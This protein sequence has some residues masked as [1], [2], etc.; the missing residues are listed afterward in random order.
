MCFDKPTP[1]LGHVALE[2]REWLGKP[3]R[4]CERAGQCFVFCSR[5]P[6][7]FS[8]IRGPNVSD[9]ILK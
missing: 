4:T 8:P 6:F 1:Q 7:P 5:F 3:S 2:I 9:N